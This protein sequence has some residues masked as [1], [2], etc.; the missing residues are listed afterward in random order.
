MPLVKADS[1]LDLAM[2]ALDESIV[3]QRLLGAAVDLSPRQQLAYDEAV[4]YAAEVDAR[5]RDYF[6]R[7]PERIKTENHQVMADLAAGKLY[8][9]NRVAGSTNVV[10]FANCT[11]IR[12]QI[13]RDVAHE[14]EI[15][16]GDVIEG[17]WHSGSG[18]GYVAKWPN[19]VTIDD[20]EAL[21]AYRACQRCNPDTKERRKYAGVRNAP[22]KLTSVTRERIGRE[23]ETPEGEYLGVLDSYTVKA[24]E[25]ILHCS[26][27][28]FAAPYDALVTMLPKGE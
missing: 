22:S 7:L 18:A 15:E 11:T 27:R 3:G 25:V 20:V 14:F 19:L 4:R 17:S 24:D 23:Y 1:I 21:R 13:D 10:H 9:V 28:D 8:L 5:E 26:E 16:R 2:P 12:H 6:E